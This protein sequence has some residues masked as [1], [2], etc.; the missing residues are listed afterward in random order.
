MDREFSTTSRAASSRNSGV[1]F[2]FFPDTDTPIFG[3]SAVS[4]GEF[5]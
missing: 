3:S 2:L 4:V 1:N 5:S